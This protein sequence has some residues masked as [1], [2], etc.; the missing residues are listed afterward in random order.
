M[1]KSTS[2]KLVISSVQPAS[3]EVIMVVSRSSGDFERVTHRKQKGW[4]MPG[5]SPSTYSDNGSLTPAVHIQWVR[6]I[7]VYP[8]VVEILN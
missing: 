5:C 6:L 1:S 3:S 4:G 7:P 2:S 8:T